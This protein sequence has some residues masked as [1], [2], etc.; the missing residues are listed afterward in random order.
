MGHSTKSSAAKGDPLSSRFAATLV[1]LIAI[2]LW[3]VLALL[4]AASGSTPPFQLLGMT[5]GIAAALGAASWL[6]RPGAAHALRQPLP[7][8]ALGVGGLFG[9]HA[10][11]FAALKSA[12][13]AEASLI[14]YLWPLLIVLFSSLLPGERLRWYHVSGAVLGFGGVVALA[15]SGGPA[16]SSGNLLGYVLALGC[17]FIWSGY[18]VLSRR[19]KAVPTDAVVGFC[20]ATALLALPFH[21]LL[22]E[23]VAPASVNE[24]LVIVGLGLGPVGAAFYAWDHGVK[25]GDIRLLGVMSYA[26]PVLSTL[27]LVLA[28]FAEPTAGLALACML[29]VGGA[30]LASRDQLWAAR[31]N[32]AEASP[33]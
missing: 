18:S 17:A 11:Y 9:Y 4:T 28:G 3:A 31:P 15:G 20:A 24:W 7:V 19:F 2:A 23:S 6:F 12:P 25:H 26:T 30:L 13:P 1:G 8:W 33:G 16:F 27:I 29:I 14:A 22:E 21:L 5:F 32:K 10:V